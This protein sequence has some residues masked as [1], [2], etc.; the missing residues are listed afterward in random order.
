MENNL[1]NFVSGHVLPNIARIKALEHI[2]ITDENRQKYNELC[3]TYLKEVLR[4]Y[5]KFVHLHEGFVEHLLSGWE[6]T[7][8]SQ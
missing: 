1:V 5:Q 4:E 8:D 2:L 6:T 3:G 7:S